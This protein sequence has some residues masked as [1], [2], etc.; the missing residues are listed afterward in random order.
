MRNALAWCIRLSCL[1]VFH[2][3]VGYRRA[4]V[5]KLYRRSKSPSFKFYLS[6]YFV[7][8]SHHPIWLNTL[9]KRF[10][11]LIC[12]YLCKNHVL[13]DRNRVGK[14][15][16]I[17]HLQSHRAGRHNLICSCRIVNVCRSQNLYFIVAC[18]AVQ[19]EKAVPTWWNTTFK[20]A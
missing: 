15:Q 20:L 19:K 13:D 8:V 9:K 14:P 7:S 6:C 12:S 18:A 1:F 10:Y 5:S 2:V 17:I 16:K 3:T 11:C 4:H